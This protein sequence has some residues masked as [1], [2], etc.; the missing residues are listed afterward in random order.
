MM[1]KKYLWTNLFIVLVSMQ[2][3]SAV[4]TADATDLDSGT[5][6]FWG[7]S[8]D[9]GTGFIQSVEFDLSPLSALG[10]S[11]DFDST[12]V[13][14]L[15]SPVIGNTS[16]LT[17]QDITADFNGTNPTSLSF[18]FATGTFG[19]GDSFRFTADTDGTTLLSS[20]LGEL[21]NGLFFT[22]LM[23]DGTTVSD[24][25]IVTE[26]LIVDGTSKSGITVTTASAVPVP[27]A[28][29]LFGAGFL[30]ITM[31]GKNYQRNLKIITFTQNP[32][33]QS[34]G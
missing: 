24:N 19:T 33:S 21:H 10:I 2:A 34:S 1:M 13:P 9:N 20:P 32:G 4:I 25:F 23:E 26:Q 31:R 16:G 30:A 14:Q 17:A 18:S 5:I 11:F 22:V 27:A 7:V 15:T 6:D 8:F 28:I 12:T 3:Q 29:W